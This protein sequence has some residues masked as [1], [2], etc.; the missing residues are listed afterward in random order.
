LSKKQLESKFASLVNGNIAWG[1]N[2]SPTSYT[3]VYSQFGKLELHWV[4]E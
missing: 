4:D 1:K 3:W 2:Y